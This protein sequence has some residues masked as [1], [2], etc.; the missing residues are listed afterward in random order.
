MIRV[1][2]K[3][4]FSFFVLLSLF[5]CGKKEYDSTEEMFADLP[6]YGLEGGQKLPMD[7]VGV[8]STNFIV[9]GDYVVTLPYRSKYSLSIYDIHTGKLLKNAAYVGEGP[10]EYNLITC[11]ESLN[12]SVFYIRTFNG[13]YHIA[14]YNLRHLQDEDI[15][16][17]FDAIDVLKV[18]RQE[19]DSTGSIRGSISSPVVCTSDTTV[20]ARGYTLGD[21]Q[22]MF[23]VYRRSKGLPDYFVDYPI[24]NEQEEN[25]NPAI[26]LN[27]YQ[28]CLA[29]NDR[30]DRVF[31]TVD[32][33]DMLGFF[34]MEGDRLEVEKMYFFDPIER[35]VSG[36]RYAYSWE[37]TLN[38]Y[39]DA[40]YHS[41]RFYALAEIEPHTLTETYRLEKEQLEAQ[42][43]GGKGGVFRRILVFSQKGDPLYSL[44]LDVNPLRIDFSGDTL[45][46]LCTNGEGDSE[47]LSYNMRNMKPL[48]ES[49][50]LLAKR[51][52]G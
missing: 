44:Y 23:A 48:E 3:L 37:K 18:Q 29:I 8:F 34:R 39:R 12:D 13:K 27:M 30:G 51:G 25:M 49:S 21:E 40:A 28:G 9:I 33:A 46:V 38:Y 10:D 17:P 43:Q 11:I 1:V 50:I 41:D 4:V 32:F 7:L 16:R 31:M 35:V 42:E 20:I 45:Y 26:R 52:G 14:F 2:K 6:R 24:R 15:F 22:K 19:K 5:S 36:D 47:I